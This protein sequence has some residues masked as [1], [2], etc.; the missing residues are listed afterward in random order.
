MATYLD[1]SKIQANG[2]ISLSPAALRNL[3]LTKGDSVDIYFDE[4]KGCLIILPASAESLSA[5]PK[6]STPDKTGK[7]KND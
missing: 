1:T 5:D 4:S 2:R 3:K 7:K 6:K